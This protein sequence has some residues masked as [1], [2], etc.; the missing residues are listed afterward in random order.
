MRKKSEKGKLID[1]IHAEMRLIRLT[2]EPQ[3]VTCGGT[4]GDS[5]LQLGHLI[6]RG[7]NSTRFDWRNLHT[8]CR[9]CN[10][11]HEYRPEIYNNWFV[12]KYGLEEYNQL[13]Y[14]SRQIKQWKM[15]ELRD[16][17]EEMKDFRKKVVK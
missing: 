2:Q 10:N 11:I 4:H 3:C 9:I 17:L 14:D 1:K 6:T 12:N 5:V 15:R 8:Q 13:V 16:L 7:A